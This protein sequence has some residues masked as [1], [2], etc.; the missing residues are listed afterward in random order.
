MGMVIKNKSKAF[1]LAS[2]LLD[3]INKNIF[4]FDCF[5]LNNIVNQT[6]NSTG[7]SSDC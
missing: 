5:N 1:D 4:L 2:F 7:N 6:D 3:S